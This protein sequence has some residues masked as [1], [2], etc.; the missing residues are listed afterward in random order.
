MDIRIPEN[1]RKKG[2]CYAVSADGVELP[3]IDVTHP[4]FTLHLEGAELGALRKRGAREHAEWERKPAFLKRFILYFARRRSVLLRG[5]MEGKGS[6]LSGMNTYLMKLGPDNLGRGYAKPLDRKVAQGAGAV[7]VR[8]RLQ[9]MARLL[10]EGLAPSLE[11]AGDG[12][13]QLVNIA[14]G[15]AMDS[16]NALILLR[17]ERPGL[18]DGRPLRILVLDADTAGPT[19]GSRALTALCDKNG[20]LEGLRV[21]FEHAPYDWTD[22]SRLRVLLGATGAGATAAGSSEGGLFEYGSDEVISANLLALRE[23]TPEGFALS[24]SFSLDTPIGRAQSRLLSLRLFSPEAFH[25]L[26]NRAGWRVDRMLP[27]TTNM[28]VRLVKA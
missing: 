16:L 5:L 14:G 23:H 3:V 17:K 15:P 24:G 18:L 10:A 9:N 25:D 11:A 6:F 7:N 22:P 26:A 13:V 8:L 20:P 2:V 19:F 4:A 28:C 1:D 27:G 12:P 21:T